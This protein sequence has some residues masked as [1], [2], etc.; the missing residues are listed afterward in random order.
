MEITGKNQ[1]GNRYSAN[2]KEKYRSFN[3]LLNADNGWDFIE[4]TSTEIEEAVVLAWKAFKSYCSTSRNDRARFLREIA[5]GLTNNELQL[6]EVYCL[7]SGL[8]LERGRGEL[9][10]TIFQLESFA[11][12]LENT[13]SFGVS[14]D[15]GDSKRMP[16]PKPELK[17]TMLP[18]GPIVVFGASNFPFA[19]STAGG[20]TASALGAGCPVIVKSHP[21]HA[22]TSELVGTII[23]RAAEKT[24]M[25]NGVFSNI[26]GLDYSIGEALVKHKYVKGVG[27]TGSIKGGRALFDLANQRKE[28][29]PVFAEMGSVNPVVLSIESLVNNHV[30]WAKKYADSIMLGAGQFCTSP[31]LFFGVKGNALDAFKSRLAKELEDSSS[32]CMLHPSI[33]KAFDNG[34]NAV[35]NEASV[36]ELISKKPTD[37]NFVEQGLVSVDAHTFKTNALLHQEVFG[38]FA[39]IVECDSYQE[40][41]EIIE[42]LEGQLTGTIIMEEAEQAEMA[43]IIRAMT[44]R[45][46]RIIYNGVSTGVEVC[47]S[48]QHGGPY[49]ASTDARFTAV[50]IHSI[51]RWLRPIAFQNFP[52]ALL[53]EELTGK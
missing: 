7:E 32:T 23:I 40:I 15:T 33:K 12:L 24:G 21:M 51:K 52:D 26:N 47:P 9:N 34:K 4:A 30:E 43:G 28:P 46:G 2:G 5:D 37:D 3:P 36:L 17:K 35:I 14:I 53:P 10:R 39:I 45:V 22:G 13:T 25:P 11:R 48:M 44:H 42:D 38:S 31:G 16:T 6:I 49:P 19:Y 1:I 27:F 18:L 29:I 41:E 50:G 20:D 8:P